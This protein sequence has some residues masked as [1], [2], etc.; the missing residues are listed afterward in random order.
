M[1]ETRNKWDVVCTRTQ[2]MR[3]ID[4]EAERIKAIDKVGKPPP[5]STVH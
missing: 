2:G 5:P 3:T 4:T 1:I